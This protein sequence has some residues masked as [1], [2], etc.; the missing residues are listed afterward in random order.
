MT[1]GIVAI[2]ASWGGIHA[3]GVVLGGLP[4]DMTAPVVIAQHRGEDAPARLGEA[5][6]RRTALRVVE[7]TDKEA[8]QPGHAYLAPPGYHLLVEHGS[9]SLSTDEPERFSRPSSCRGK[10]RSLRG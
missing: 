6:G 3:I 10:L 2:G 4:P 5:L 7:A 9:L 1:C 8:L